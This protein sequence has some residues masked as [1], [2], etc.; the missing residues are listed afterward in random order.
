MKHHPETFASFYTEEN[1]AFSYKHAHEAFKTYEP[2]FYGKSCLE[3]GPATG[4]MTKYLL[5]YFDQVV[6]L[7]GSSTLLN[8]IPEHT[9]LRK[10]N[11]LF[12]NFSPEHSFDTIVCNHI[13]EHIDDTR[14]FLSRVRSWMDDKTVLIV[15]VPNAKSF[16]RLAAVE[17]GLLA[18]EYDLNERD[19]ALGHFRVYDMENL[20]ADIRSVG[21]NIVQTGGIFLKFLSNDQT[22]RLLSIEIIDAYFK[23]A[24][25]FPSNAAEVFAVCKK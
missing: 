7:E 22:K 1:L 13:L 17:M 20:L 8:Q 2:Y 18:S 6:A 23:L 3:M 19:K 15:G 21:L 14:A 12:E 5:E 16:H 9:S 25:Q 11:C 10:V 24:K 4:Y